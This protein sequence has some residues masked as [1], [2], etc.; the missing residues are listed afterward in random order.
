MKTFVYHV[1]ICF[2]DT[3]A[4]GIVYHA[5]YLALAEQARTAWQL[6]VDDNYTNRN[7]MA[8]GEVFVIRS[9]NLEYLRPALLD[10]EIDIVCMTKELGGASGTFYQEFK[11][12]DELLVALTIKVVM[13]DTKTG[14]PK[15][16]VPELKEKYAEYMMENKGE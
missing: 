16:F 14:R 8:R 7:M 10:D 9:V 1:R 12:G 13:I 2:K 3:D 4:S 15:R 11:R 6:Q 5:N